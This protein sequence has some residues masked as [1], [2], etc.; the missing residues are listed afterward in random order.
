MLFISTIITYSNV[1]VW[2][3]NVG[4]EIDNMENKVILLTNQKTMNTPTLFIS[5]YYGKQRI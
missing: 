1:G 2:I 3:H 5:K 4:V